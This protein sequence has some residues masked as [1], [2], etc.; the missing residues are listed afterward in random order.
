MRKFKL[1]ISLKGNSQ[2]SIFPALKLVRIWKYKSI[3]AHIFVKKS[4]FILEEGV[5]QCR[6]LEG[7]YLDSYILFVT[8]ELD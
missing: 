7:V 8:R 4:R 3:R 1:I 2:I 6:L 5:H